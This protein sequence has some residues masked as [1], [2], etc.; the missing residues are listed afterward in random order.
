MENRIFNKEMECM[1]RRDMEAL[2]LERLKSLVDYCEKNSEFYAKR[3]A[4]AGVTADKIKCLSDIEYIPYTTKDDLRDTYPFGMLSVPMEKIVRVHAS[5]GTTGNPTVVAYTRED[6]ENWSEQV[7][8]LAV[9]GGATAG[10]IVQICFGYGMFTGALG[11]HYGL[12]K[13]GAVVVPTSSGNTEKQLKF[14]RDFGTNAIVATPSYCM[15]LAEAARSMQDKYPMDMY[16]LK[17]GILG[18]EGSTPEMRTEIENHWGNGF[19]CTDNY[20]MSELNGPG[21]SGECMYRDG[22]HIN[23]DHFLC[24]VIDSASGNVLE[25]GST[26]ELVV[27]NLTKRG[28]PML[29]YR[30]K[31]ITNINYEPCKCGRTSARMHKIIGR[32]DD[33]IKVRGV[34]VFPTQVESALI[35]MTEISPNYLIVL[36]RENY[37]DS[38]EVRVELIDGG[39]LDRYGELVAL[40]KR[41]QDNIK[42]ILGIAIKVTLV[43]PNSIERFTGKAKR[44]LDLRHENK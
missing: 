41:I 1:S 25:K 40:Q 11:L 31:D 32:S 38:M 13:I 30:T 14:M 22:L 18:S 23:E 16:K 3:L 42:N 9:A 44:V 28:L 29:R 2:Q 20:G 4:K 43:E 27:T 33:M 17:Y 34:N 39:L 21:M 36:R 26:G 15:Y 19:F 12:E 7:A 6:L 35:G 5:S 24:E 37:S 10:T 8:R